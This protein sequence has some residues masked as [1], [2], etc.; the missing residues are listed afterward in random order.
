MPY[1]ASVPV[2]YYNQKA[3]TAAHIAAAPKTMTELLADQRT[4]QNLTLNNGVGKPTKMKYGIS[5]KYDPW[6]ITSWA[7]LGNIAIVNNNNGHSGRATS[8]TFG[9]NASL[10]SYLA[11]MQTIAKTGGGLNV[12]NPSS[13]TIT[14]AYGNLYDIGY[15]YSGI[16]FDTTAALGTILA[17][18]GSFSNVKLGV[19]PLPTLTGTSTGGMPS[20]GNGLFINSTNSSAAQQAASWTFI[21]YLTNATNLANW[22]AQTGYLPIRT[23]EV[24]PWKADLTKQAHHWLQPSLPTWFE[25]GYASLAAGKTTTSSEGPLIGAYNQVSMDMQTA[26]EGLLTTPFT[27]TPAQALTN[28]AANATSDIHSYNNGL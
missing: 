28:A 18:L 20:G 15:G 9:T 1:S 2:M 10:K 22:D 13:T 19:A 17:Y 5:I 12:Y 14:E 26:L 27:T 4:L 3:L 8:A 11:D 16:T 24:T 7:G 23:D 21:Q 25:T 6:E